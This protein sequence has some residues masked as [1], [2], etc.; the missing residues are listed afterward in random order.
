MAQG[1][2]NEVTPNPV[3]IRYP[4]PGHGTQAK[5]LGGKEGGDLSYEMGISLRIR[6]SEQ[7]PEFG[8]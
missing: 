7:I 1:K 8:S 3:K 2:R 6:Q 4:V 5:A